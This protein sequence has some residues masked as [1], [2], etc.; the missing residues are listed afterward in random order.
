MKN[1]LVAIIVLAWVGNTVYTDFAPQI[2]IAIDAFNNTP[3]EVFGVFAFF[4][5]I[6]IISFVSPR[7]GF[8]I[9][10]FFLWGFVALVVGILAGRAIGKRM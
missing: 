5:A 9:V 4:T 1:A 6:I 10:K 8:A 7:A 2:Q 3:S